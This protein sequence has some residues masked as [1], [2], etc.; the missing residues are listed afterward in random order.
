MKNTRPEAKPPPY[1]SDP[2]SGAINL[3]SEVVHELFHLAKGNK[4]EAVKRVRELTG[5]GLQAAK[6]YVEALDRRR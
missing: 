5:V 3:P 1:P 2:A 6:A 4:L